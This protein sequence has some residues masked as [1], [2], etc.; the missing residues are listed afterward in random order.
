MNIEWPPEE[1]VNFN[2]KNPDK[3]NGLVIKAETGGKPRDNKTNQ[4]EDQLEHK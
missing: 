3:T 1:R 2:A 4:K